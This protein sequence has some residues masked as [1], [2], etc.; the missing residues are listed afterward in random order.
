MFPGKK[1]VRYF[2][3]EK[4]IFGIGPIFWLYTYLI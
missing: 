2:D 4:F 3:N 1:Y